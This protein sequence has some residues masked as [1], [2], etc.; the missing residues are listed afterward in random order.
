M[1][2]GMAN[3]MPSFEEDGV[4]DCDGLSQAE[5]Q[6]AIEA[7]NEDDAPGSTHQDANDQALGW[8]S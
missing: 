5:L 6:E 7:R 8:G 3:E 4:D 1:A 2:S